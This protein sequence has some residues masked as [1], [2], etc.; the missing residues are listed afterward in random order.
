MFPCCISWIIP[1]LHRNLLISSYPFFLIS[2]LQCSR[3]SL[4]LSSKLYRACHPVSF[5]NFEVSGICNV[6]S[7]G[8]KSFGSG[9]ETFL[10]IQD[11]R[12]E[13][14]SESRLQSLPPEAQKKWRKD[15]LSWD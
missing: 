5:L 15:R 6:T 4:T 13:V 11:C 1:K 14:F 2:S 8:L 10:Q 3:S 7:A 12:E 9:F